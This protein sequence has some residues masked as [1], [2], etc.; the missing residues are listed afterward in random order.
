VIRAATLTAIGLLALSGCGQSNQSAPAADTSVTSTGATAPV[1]ISGI[2]VFNRCASC[3]AVKAGAPNGI[4]PNLHNIVNAKIANV[5]GFEY[6]KGLKAKAGIWDNT[7]LDA[8]IA[9]PAKYAPGTKMMFAGLAKPEER[10]AVIEYLAT[11]K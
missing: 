2:A 10:A 8:Y 4:G 3:H 9:S 5:A 1:A 11:L 7:A 6:S